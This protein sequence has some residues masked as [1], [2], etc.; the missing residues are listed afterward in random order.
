MG[1]YPTLTA[2]FAAANLD[3][4]DNNWDKVHHPW[5]GALLRGKSG[6]A[7]LGHM[8]GSNPFLCSAQHALI[9]ARALHCDTVCPFHQL[10][11]PC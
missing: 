10:N 4:L 11:R 1:A 5:S 9:V 7:H 2:H 6:A 8:C 3:P